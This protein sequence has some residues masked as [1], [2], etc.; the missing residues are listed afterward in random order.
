M[1]KLQRLE[2]DIRGMTCDSCALHVERALKKVSGVQEAEVPGWES[3]RASV[4]LEGD[5]DSQALIESV[6]KAGYGASVKARKPVVEREVEEPGSSDG[7]EDGRLDLMVIGA[8]SAGFA[9]AIKAAELGYRVAM[10]EAGT[11]GGTCVNVGCVP[12]KTLIRAMEQYHLAGTH[13]FQGVEIAA[14]HLR[15]PVI[16]DH[17]D[18]LVEE[19]RQSKY[20][21]VLAAYPEITYLQ[22]RA[23]LTGDNG[24]EIDGKTYTP[25]K[26]LITTGARSWAPPIPGLIEAGFLTSTTAMELKELPRSMIVLGANAVGLELA[27]TFARAGT[28]VTVLELLPRVAPFEDAEISEALEG[29][30]EEEGLEIFTDFQTTRVE[31]RVGRYI[32]SGSKDGEEMV[33]DAEQLL[34]ATGRRPNTTGLGLEEAGVKLG[35]RGEIL[36]DERL[37]T[38]NPEVYAAGDVTGQDM[39]V[40]VAAYGG[41]LAAENA[42]TGAGRVYDAAYIP[43]ITFTDPQIAS[44]GLTEE[45]AREQGY[46]VQVSTLPMSYVPRALAARDLRGLVKMVADADTDRLL[47][48]HILAPEA[49]E[50]IQTAV[51]AIRFGITLTQLRETMFPY[52]TNVEGV[53]LAALAFEKDV[54][55]LSCCAG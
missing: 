40:Y 16:I 9:A 19:M 49:G 46:S 45:Q 13:R 25:G 52:L 17:K 12:S 15:W 41:G 6:R 44:T 7:R 33:F 48:A 37:Q 27:Q 8:G 3:G 43:R 4:L 11:I 5:V 51:L 24:V 34:V 14:G 1:E 29:Y 31:K 20:V 35:P 23:R 53:K 30:L 50:M 54:A 2:F 42:L 39:F 26:I 55:L 10:V 21:D 36:V 22:G 28:N 32:L 38:S 18:R 47:G